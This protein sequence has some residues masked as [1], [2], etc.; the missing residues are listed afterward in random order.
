MEE[1]NT[2]NKQETI[3]KLK[4][5]GKKLEFVPQFKGD[6]DVVLAAVKQNGRALEY[7]SEE[8]KSDKEVVLAAVAQTV[9]ALKY[10][11]EE[12]KGDKEVI[13]VVVTQNGWA[14]NYASKE[15]K[16][17]KEVVL[18]AVKQNRNALEYA[19][20]ELK[21]DK[22]FMMAA[23]TKN[24]HALEYAS[25]DLKRDKEFI[26]AAVNQYGAAL[27]YASEE[28]KS[29]REIVLAAVTQDGVALEYA[30]EELKGD[31][32]FILAAVTQDSWALEY[33]SEE[34]KGDKEVVLAA[35]KQ[36]GVALRYAS[37]DLK[38]DKEVVLAA[39]SQEVEILKFASEELKANKEFMLDVVT[40]DGLALEYASEDLKQDK[41]VVLAAV[42]Q[43]GLALEY[44]FEELK[45]DKEVVLAAVTQNIV[46]LEYA[47]EELKQD[48]EVLE[49]IKNG[50]IIA[51]SQN[52]LLLASIS[53][54]D[55]TEEMCFIAV[56]Q[57]NYAYRYV[58]KELITPEL[59]KL[60]PVKRGPPSL[61]RQVSETKSN[62]TSAPTCSYHSMSRLF[63]QNRFIFVKP[64]QVDDIYDK[65]DCN[66]FLIPVEVEKTGLDTLDDMRCS[67]GGYDKIL[68]FLYIYFL[69]KETDS[70]KQSI[71][72]LI[73]RQVDAIEIP[74]FLKSTK[75]EHRL[76][77]LLTEIKHLSSGLK[78]KEYNFL[79]NSIEEPLLFSVVQKLI[80]LRFY[81]QLHC[82]GGRDS[83]HAV[84]IV[85][86]Q[87]GNYI[88]KNSW[89]ILVDIV[90]SIKFF[91]LKG[92]STPWMGMELL[93]Y[94][95]IISSEPTDGVKGKD[96]DIS[97]LTMF[98]AWLDN[99]TVEIQRK[100]KGGRKTKRKKGT[101]RIKHK[102]TKRNLK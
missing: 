13:L 50:R 58:P 22:E 81:V 52:G 82:C 57:N 71:G 33:A 2:L 76:L 96:Y 95:P 17:D 85:G 41:E 46:T 86:V 44:A 79:F 97:K 75:H 55:L 15:L 93:I 84:T 43:N 67:S 69:L 4:L 91:Y 30:S 66:R 59:V 48:K 80:N 9:A 10:V 63:L 102:R 99:Y 36:S 32:E 18:A 38:G 5:N 29:D 90:P 12:L 62:Q 37:E 70:C 87:E 56:R 64:L 16:G 3:A 31:K 49:K 47:S 1:F 6:K 7:V 34:L 74:V 19:S 68:L 20:E 8:L 83:G 94:I 35:V 73:P 53:V 51:L 100:P 65:N 26:L 28:L 89:S 88:I 27:K 54:G 78:W 45:G 60:L 23:V 14:L 24:I 92:W 11:S 72:E 77:S 40:Q 25:E 42:K 101:R 98:D 61:T 21:A 39:I